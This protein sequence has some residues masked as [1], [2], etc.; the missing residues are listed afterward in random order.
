MLIP[1][2][3]LNGHTSLIIFVSRDWLYQTSSER[4]SST[5]PPPE[6]RDLSWHV[7]ISSWRDGEDK[8]MPATS[9]YYG[10][11]IIYSILQ[12]ERREI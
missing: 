8:R 12:N 4:K 6:H 3:L 5:V 11:S 10:V 1:E 7:E 2:P 9:K